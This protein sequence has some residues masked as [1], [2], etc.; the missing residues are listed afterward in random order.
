VGTAAF[1]CPASEASQSQ[2]HPAPVIL[3]EV[4][5]PRSEPAT[6]SK[7][8]PRAKPRG[9]LAVQMPRLPGE[10]SSSGPLFLRVKPMALFQSRIRISQLSMSVSA[11]LRQSLREVHQCKR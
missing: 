3:S 1:G 9:S 6:Q 7:S 5:G 11:W 2:P 10:L 8:L 4:A